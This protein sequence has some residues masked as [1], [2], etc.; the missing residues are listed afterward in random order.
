MHG[1]PPDLPLATF[2]GH[3]CN[4]IALGQYQVQF[5]F[6]GAGSIYAESRWELR[7]PTGEIIDAMC[8]HRK[9]DCYRVHRIIDVPVSRFAI[10]APL[11]FTL[12]FASGDTLTIFDD[13]DRCESFSV[14][15]EVGGSFFI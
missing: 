4:Q 6:A 10:D 12:F 14:H 1:V 11:S 9:R 7:G 15:L 13:S 8:E 2:V 3:E 5:C